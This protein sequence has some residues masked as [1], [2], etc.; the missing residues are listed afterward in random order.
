LPPPAPVSSAAVILFQ[1]KLCG[2]LHS[3][4][5]RDHPRFKFKVFAVYGKIRHRFCD[6]LAFREEF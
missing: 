2:L 4:L 1:L 6:S 3:R 5:A